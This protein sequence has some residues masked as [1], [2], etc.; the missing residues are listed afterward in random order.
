[1]EDIVPI[2]KSLRCL[3]CGVEPSHRI[4]A[5]GQFSVMCK[6]NC[7]FEG[8]TLLEAVKKY[9]K[10][11]MDTFKSMESAVSMPFEELP[12]YTNDHRAYFRFAVQKRLA[13]Q[14]HST[15]AFQ[16]GRVT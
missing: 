4:N 5:L 7:S 8:E 2:E 9:N 14:D 13:G 15:K 6:C 1:M 16:E 10:V 3:W 12:K 11:Q